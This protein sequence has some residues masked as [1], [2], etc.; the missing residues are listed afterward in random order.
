MLVTSD[1]EDLQYVIRYPESYKD[2]DK[3]PVLFFFHGSGTVGKDI[4]LVV[5]NSFFKL[6][7]QIENFPFI[8]IAPQCKSHS[9]IAC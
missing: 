2:G 8:C 1:F 5:N 9:C 6:T 7:A 3:C 4:T